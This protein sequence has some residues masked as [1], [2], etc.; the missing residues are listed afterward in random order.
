MIRPQSA[1]MFA[2]EFMR[3]LQKNKRIS[4]TVI[5]VL[6]KK[7]ELDHPAMEFM[8]RRLKIAGLIAKLIEPN[9]DYELGVNYST[10]TVD[11]FCL[12]C[13]SDDYA[14]SA[15]PVISDIFKEKMR[16]LLLDDALKGVKVKL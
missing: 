15:L 3:V 13:G 6:S 8:L 7:W 11:Q 4:R 10:I 16:T 1:L 5:Y 9:G 14:D 12:V 2:I